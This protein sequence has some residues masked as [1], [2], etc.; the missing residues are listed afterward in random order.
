M[1]EAKL[2]GIDLAKL[3]QESFTSKQHIA[4]VREHELRAAKYWDKVRWPDRPRATASDTPLDAQTFKLPI[5]VRTVRQPS[6]TA[7]QIRIAQAVLEGEIR[8]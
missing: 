1:D 3:A 8:Q 6:F 4:M 7:K 5:R 2:R